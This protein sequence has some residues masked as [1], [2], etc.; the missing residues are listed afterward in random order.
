MKKDNALFVSKAM[1]SRY[2]ETAYWDIIMKGAKLLDPAKLPT[3]MGRLDD[4]TTVEKHATKIFM[5][6]AGYGISY[7][8]QRRCRRL[9]RRLFEM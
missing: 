5:E 4:F 8:N 7:A 1:Q 3:A 6:E 2:N 9:W